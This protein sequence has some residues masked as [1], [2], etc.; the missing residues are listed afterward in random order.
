[1]AGAA[2]FKIPEWIGGVF[3]VYINNCHLPLVP[4][5]YFFTYTRI[6]FVG[7]TY[8]VHTYKKRVENFVGRVLS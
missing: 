1:M 3:H 5:P 7:N 8:V 6:I 2:G 4:M